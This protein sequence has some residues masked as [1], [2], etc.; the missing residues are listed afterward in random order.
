[1][2]KFNPSYLSKLDYNNFYLNTFIILYNYN[3]HVGVGS[4]RVQAYAYRNAAGSVFQNK[5]WID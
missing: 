5:T 2:H 3:I 4:G 1:M